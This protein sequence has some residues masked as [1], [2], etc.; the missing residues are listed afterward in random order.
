M[1]SAF[2]HALVA[3]TLG[4]LSHSHV[5]D[6]HALL[7]GVGCSVLPDVDVIGFWY[8]VQYGDLWGHRG[9]THS[10]AFAALVSALLVALRYRRQS[11]TVM[12]GMGLYFFLCAASHGVLDALTDGGLGVAFFSPFDT[13]RYFFTVRPVAVSPIGI[14]EFFSDQAVRVL[15]SEAKWIWLPACAGFIALRALRQ[16]WSQKQAASRSQAD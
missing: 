10:L 7:L 3:L 16:A 5:M 15:A 4:K 2:S 6:R 12:A 1:A 11:G 14:Q 9:L 13:T 8:G